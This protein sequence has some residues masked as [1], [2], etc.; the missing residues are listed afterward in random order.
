MTG[1]RKYYTKKKDR[2]E[3][4][5]RQIT[6]LRIASIAMREDLMIEAVDE[7]I[8]LNRRFEREDNPKCL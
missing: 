6:K 5:I 3:Q 1:P 7:L 4:Y 2:I 8:S